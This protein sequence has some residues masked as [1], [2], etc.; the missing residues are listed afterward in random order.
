[1]TPEVSRWSAARSS[2]LRGAFVA[3]VVEPAA[4]L[5]PTVEA[6]GTGTGERFEHAESATSAHVEKS[7][8]TWARRMKRD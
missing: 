7:R 6:S 2:A 8:K 4:V 5:A 1:M 3:L